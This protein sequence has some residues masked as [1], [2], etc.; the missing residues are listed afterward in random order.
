MDIKGAWSSHNPLEAN[1]PNE[2]WPCDTDKVH[3]GVSFSC[4]EFKLK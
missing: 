4:F 1:K 2:G 3:E